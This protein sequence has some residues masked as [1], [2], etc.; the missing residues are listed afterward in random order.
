MKI[1]RFFAPDMRQAIRLVREELGPDAVILSNRRVEGG[2]EI[3]SA[4]D[5]DEA[6]LGEALAEPAV[7]GGGEAP[8]ETNKPEPAAAPV[9]G[10]A[11]IV[12]AQDPAIMAMQNEIKALR[13][14]LE[15]QLS[16]LA[17]REMG[18]RQPLRAG[19]LKRLSVLGL[20]HEL[21]LRLAERALESGDQ[22]HLWERALGLLRDM[23]Q[24]TDDDI[25]S[26]G[27]VVALVGPTGVGK[28]TSVAK[29]AARF[30][31]RHGRRYV[32]LVSMDGFRI[33]GQEQLRTFGRILGVPVQTANTREELEAVLDDL[34]DRKLVLVDTAGISQ[35]DLKLAE[36]LATIERGKAP[37]KTYL[38]LSAAAQTRVQGEAVR[39]F[40]RI[41]LDGC[42]LTKLDETAGLGGVLSVLAGNRLPVAYLGNGQRV[43]EDMQPARTANLVE[44]LVELADKADDEMNEERLAEAFGGRMANAHV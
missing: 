1:K 13:G 24:V 7:A 39:A 18:R 3:V 16:Q 33:G 20:D 15:G 8:P 5:Y 29:L 21:C 25:L 36:R 35:R 32:G 42:I 28:T 17:W 19:L 6:L 10:P 9:R 34:S 30:A 43:P 2:V 14:M 23:L 27:G 4:V 12:W 41:A 31:L 11:D 22:E 26:N 44:R 38:V 37:I 40:G